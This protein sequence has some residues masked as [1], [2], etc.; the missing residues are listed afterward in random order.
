MK[1]TDNL[2]PRLQEKIKTSVQLEEL[3][4]RYKKILLFHYCASDGRIRKLREVGEEFDVTRQRIWN[5]EERIFSRLSDFS[6][7]NSK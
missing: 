7:F 1:I 4:P 5:I 6:E 3:S 2:L